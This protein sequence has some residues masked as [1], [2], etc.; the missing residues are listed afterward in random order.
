MVGATGTCERCGNFM[1]EVCSQRG[2]HILCPACRARTGDL[3]FPL[4]RDTWNFGALWDYC[5][6]AFKRDWLMLSVAV[7]VWLAVGTVANITTN[8]ASAVLQN[9]D[10]WVLGGILLLISLLVQTAVQGVMAMGMVRVAFDVLEGGGVDIARLFSQFSKVGRYL[11]T[12]LLAA[13]MLVL[14]LVLLF[15]VLSFV[16]LVAVGVSVG[17]VVGGQSFGAGRGLALVGV[18]GVAGVLTLIPAF[19]FGLPLY[20]MQAELTF[21]DDVSP[22][23]ALRNCYTLARGERLSILGVSMFVGLVVLGGMLAC[24]V[25]VL[26]ALGLGQL[27]LG[28]L[29]LAL[30][31]GSELERG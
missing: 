9:S 4:R 14:P 24:C 31:N 17:D 30:R 16:G 13:V 15:C 27:M 11:V 28:G 12:V 3:A 5:F 2:R 1:C 23:Q 8:I 21:N 20:L 25:G 7:I 18:F 19:Y 26:P 22:T 6:E 29:Y 10:A